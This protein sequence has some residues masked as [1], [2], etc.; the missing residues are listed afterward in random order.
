VFVD[1]SVIHGTGDVCPVVEGNVNAVN[2]LLSLKESLS[3][4]THGIVD[5]TSDSEESILKARQ[6]QTSAT[7]QKMFSLLQ[8]S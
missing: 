2:T 6:I 4:Y 7:F 5:L 3:S 8:E 1:D